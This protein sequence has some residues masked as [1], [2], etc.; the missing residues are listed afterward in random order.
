MKLNIRTIFGDCTRCLTFGLLLIVVYLVSGKLGLMLALPPGYTSP[1]FPPAGIAIAAALIAGRRTLLP[2]FIGSLLLNVWVDY[3]ASQQINSMGWLVA[4]AI[5]CASVLQAGAGGWILRRVIGHPVSLDR[6]RE[7]LRLLIFIPLI[8]LI[9]A[10]LSITSLWLMGSVPSENFSENWFFWWMGDTLGVVV[11]LPVVMTVAGQPKELWRSRRLTVAAPILL[12][13]SL[14]VVIFLKTSHWENDNSLSDFRQISQQAF[15]QVHTK[16]EEQM[17]LLDDLTE[18][19]NHD[20]HGYVGRDEFHRFVQK[21]LQRFSMIQALEWAPRVETANRASF[22]AAQRADLP[23]FQIRE[24]D[25]AGVLVRAGERAAFYPVT[26]VEPAAGN[27]SSIGYDL[28]SSLARREALA[29]AVKTGEIVMTKAV[30]LVQDIRPQAGVLI[31][32]AI[33]PQNEKSG[34]VLTVL[35]MNDFMNALLLD[36]QSMLYT[37]LVDVDEKKVLYDNFVADSSQAL[38]E[39]SFVFGTRHYQLL[40]APTPA[41]FTQH[42]GW[43]SIAVLTAGLVGIGLMAMLLLLGTGYTARIAKEV[44][45]KTKKLAESETI[46]GYILNTSPIAVRVATQRGR[47]IVFCNARYETLIANKFALGD[48]P[49]KYYARPEEYESL[50]LELERGISVLNREIELRIPDGST[51]HVLSSYLLMEYQGEA[52]VLG[53][54]Y[55]ITAQKNTEAAYKR[56]SEKALALLHNA[57]DGIH[58]L[59]PDGNIVEASDS[60]CAMLGYTRDEVIG[61]NVAQWDVHFSRG[62]LAAMIANLL[63]RK[64]RAEFETRHKRKDGS[65]FDV[66]ISNTSLELDGKPLL[67]NSSRDITQRKQIEASLQQERDKLRAAFENPRIGFV[68]CD[69]L[70][71]DITM[72][73][74]A[75]RLH[76]FS[77]AAEMKRSVAEY[78][79]DWELRYL[80]GRLIPYPDWPLMRAIRGDFVRDFEFQYHHIKTGAQWVCNLTATAVRNSEGEVVLI[81]QTLQDITERKQ[82]EDRFRAAVEAAPNGM[83][84]V[85]ARGEIVILNSQIS[86]LFGYTERE[87][88]GQPVNLLLPKIIHEAHTAHVKSFI[89]HPVKRAMGK[90]RDLFGQHQSGRQIQVEVGLSPLQINGEAFV[91]ASVVDI[92]ERQQT[93]AQLRV[94]AEQLEQ[95]N[96]KIEEERAQLAARVQERTAQLQFANH[97]KDSFLATMSHEIRTPLGGLLGMMELLSLSQLNDTQTELLSTAQT[98]GNSLLRIVNDILDWS[99]IEAGKLE[100]SPRAT[101]I[102]QV[103]KG[104][105]ATYTQLANDKDIRLQLNIDPALL[106]AE[107]LFDPLRL[108]QIINNFTSNAI[109]FT[110][111]GIVEIRAEIIMRGEDRDTLRISVQDSG[112]GIAKEQ[113]PRLFQHYEQGSADTARMYGGTG[114]GL[115][116]CRRLAELM[117]GELSVESQSETGS[118][119]YLTI[120]LPVVNRLARPLVQP[121]I[122]PELPQSDERFTGPLA[123]NG[124]AVAVLIV[125][126]HPINRMLLKQQLDLLGVQVESAVDGAQALSK[127]QNGHFDLVITDCHMPEMDGYELT[128]NIRAIEQTSAAGH[129]PIIAWTANVLAEE[130][131]RC[132]AAGMDDLLTKPTELADL[133]AMLVKWLTPPKSSL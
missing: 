55:D 7:I 117:S 107:Y 85:N 26:Y 119:F 50:L 5:A 112:V 49:K 78:Q 54:F 73:E 132:H 100:L 37:R 59:D 103:L 101:A 96:A 124:Q 60:F 67:F 114:L 11:M 10:T 91:L 84:I 92:T 1:I 95:A 2:I 40:T 6:G 48:D 81:L 83:M 113:L 75:L 38:G 129:I 89:A 105:I 28:A 61:M 29:H 17:V 15:N 93:L 31:L 23:Q 97:A 64:A 115:S 43:Q 98:S 51:V 68:L 87:L 76:H 21:S 82:S 111:R 102:S 12:I 16:L 106:D 14:F 3:S 79:F 8:C 86:T 46:L 71:S 20:K 9:S 19:F 27:E 80:D 72:N 123:V 45:D 24:R 58:I 30:Q 34:V 116:I 62:T 108:S 33:S 121:D 36:T 99:K 90:G 53:W 109:K 52:A 18:L 122:A 56:E 22:E 128:R 120:S 127:W 110:E 13:F 77:S 94:T 70:G 47:K 88:I 131:Y 125:D 74:T 57:S 130:S 39:Y 32:S 133:R 44:K 104:V 63:Q 25:A 69:A 126:D 118:T 65:E 41:Y 42:R 35:K 4:T 66:E